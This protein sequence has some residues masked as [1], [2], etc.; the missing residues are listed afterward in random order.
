MRSPWQ[1][2]GNGRIKMVFSL[3]EG[4][5]DPKEL[6]KGAK[7]LRANVSWIRDEV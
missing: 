5:L 3:P 2:G 4:M 7:T 1:E 6:R